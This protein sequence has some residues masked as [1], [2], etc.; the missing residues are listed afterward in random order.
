MWEEGEEGRQSNIELD[1]CILAFFVEDELI[2]NSTA[3]GCQCE[4]THQNTKQHIATQHNT[5]HT[6]HTTQT[7]L[8]FLTHHCPHYYPMHN[9][10]QCKVQYRSDNMAVGQSKRHTTDRTVQYVTASTVLTGSICCDMDLRGAGAASVPALVA[11][12]ASR[13][14]NS[15]RS[16]VKKRQ[17][18]TEQNRVG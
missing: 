15:L 3:I 2:P 14:F 13:R 4:R 9:A 11:A 7:D 6:S 16:W 17:D 1:V 5:S 12:S 18:R 10:A 8:Q